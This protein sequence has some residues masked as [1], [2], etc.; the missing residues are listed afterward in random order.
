MLFGPHSSSHA[1]GWPTVWEAELKAVGR[2]TAKVFLR[3][4]TGRLHGKDESELLPNYP[5]V[6]F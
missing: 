4:G 5:P 2:A 3:E 1:L 6:D